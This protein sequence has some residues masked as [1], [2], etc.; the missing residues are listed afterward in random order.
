MASKS[1]KIKKFIKFK[2]KILILKIIDFLLKRFQF[3]LLPN[4]SSNYLKNLSY[5]NETN[6]YFFENSAKKINVMKIET[7][8]YHTDLCEIGTKFG[9]DKSPFNKS[10]HRHPYTAIYDLFFSNF[11]NQ[12]FN[13]AEIGILKNNSTKMFRNYFN[14]AK[15]YA[16]DYDAKLLSKAKSHK[17]KNTFYSTMNVKYSKDINDSFK[18]LKK[19]FKIIIEDTTHEFSDQIRVIENSI[20]FLE[21]GGLLIIEDIFY[22]KNIEFKYT[23]ALKKYLK[24]FE[25][26]LFIECNHINKHS[27]GWNNDKIMVLKKK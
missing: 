1:R 9:T 5:S 10:G 23:K 8:N 21:P 12:K 13:F 27:K 16:F 17:L 14:K 26:I 6:D 19:K 2:L 15:I 25:K 3:Y 24:Y 18:R 11:R 4:L 22:E 7:S 20:E